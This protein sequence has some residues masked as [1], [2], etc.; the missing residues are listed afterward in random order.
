MHLPKFLKTTSLKKKFQKIE[1]LL[2]VTLLLILFLSLEIIRKKKLD[3]VFRNSFNFDF[4]KKIILVTA[5]RRE[6]FGDGISNICD[7]IKY[8]SKNIKNK[9]CIPCSLKSQYKKSSF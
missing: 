8:L 7:A 3:Q 5:H 4:S 1:L 9:F 6:N 2:L